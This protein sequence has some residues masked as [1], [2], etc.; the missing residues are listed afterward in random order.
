MG[1]RIFGGVEERVAE[2]LGVQL[3]DGGDDL[4]DRDVDR[5]PGPCGRL[6]ID[7]HF[8][9][10]IA[11]HAVIIAEAEM[12]DREADLAV[13]RIDRVGARGDLAQVGDAGRRLG[14]LL[15]EGGQ[16]SAQGESD[17]YQ[18][19]TSHYSILRNEKGRRTRARR[20]P[21]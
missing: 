17:G 14:K 10:Q 13:E 16:G 8:S 4:A 21:D 2:Q 15:G 7:H 20:P 11:E 3:V 9:R 12:V 18:R 1:G 5:N 19:G 6:G